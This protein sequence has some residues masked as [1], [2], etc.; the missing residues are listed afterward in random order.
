MPSISKSSFV[1]AVPDLKASAAFYRD[2]LG[3]TIH[4][5]PD[6]GWL[7]YTCGNCTIMAGECRDA[8]PPRKL[9]DHAYFAYL[10]VDDIDSFYESVRLAA[11]KSEKVFVMSPG[12]CGSSASSPAMAIA[13]CS[14]LRPRSE[15]VRN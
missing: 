3:F 7:F 5:I 15:L 1:I 9:G 4:N 11:W 2:I 14:A 12:E 10:Q 13:S 8:I 6:P